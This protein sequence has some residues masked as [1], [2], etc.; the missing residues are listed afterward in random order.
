MLAKAS[1]KG[2]WKAESKDSGELSR[3]TLFGCPISNPK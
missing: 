1:S 3:A 2:E